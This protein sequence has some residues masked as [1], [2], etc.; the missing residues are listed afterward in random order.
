MDVKPLSNTDITSKLQLYGINV[1]FL[2]YVQIKYVK[3]INDILPCIL[4]YQL[5]FPIGHW[6]CLFRNDEGINY[7]DS[8]GNV[9]DE[10]LITNFDNIL[11][12][13][14]LNADY[15]Y[16]NRLLYENGEKVIYNEVELQPPE[17]MTCGF[18][19]GVRLL[20]SNIMND[21]FVK[22]FKLMPVEVREDKIV[23]CW[24]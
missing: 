19:A 6:C 5:H 12:R 1:N 14:K 24:N 21:D 22:I 20:T 10:L 15:T 13:K 3:N 16:L 7:F 23:K 17:T 9:P 18:W 4:L 2:P 11:G 8:T